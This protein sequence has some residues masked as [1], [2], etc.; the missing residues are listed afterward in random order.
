MGAQCC[1]GD[2]AGNSNDLRGDQ[3]L[4]RDHTQDLG[5]SEDDSNTLNIA[6][7][8]KKASKKKNVKDPTNVFKHGGNNIFASL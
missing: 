7:G 3:K 5:V 8:T 4:K 2:G 1:R 6:K